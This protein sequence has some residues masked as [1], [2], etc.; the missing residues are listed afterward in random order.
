MRTF[1]QPILPGEE[2]ELSLGTP[3]DFGEPGEYSLRIVVLYETDG[4]SANDTLETVIYHYGNPEVELEEGDTLNTTLPYT[5]DA[6]AEF[7]SYL[8]N[9]TAGTST[10]DV[11]TF[12]LLRLVVL[13]ENGCQG[14]DSV[15][16]LPPTSVE[17]YLLDGNLAIYP[18]PASG[19]LHLEYTHTEYDDL[20]LELF[21]AAGRKIYIRDY[22]D[23]NE[24]REEMDVSVLTPGMYYL[25]I[26][27]DS[28]MLGRRVLV[29]D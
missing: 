24:I 13:D 29:T 12:G 17:D 18:Q 1:T 21:D 9:G 16:V 2:M 19:I 15:Y 26:R 22:K 25:R 5:I 7:S 23:V 27:S 11:E 6:G 14:M 10:Y 20:L 8:W 28:E 4:Y 3:F